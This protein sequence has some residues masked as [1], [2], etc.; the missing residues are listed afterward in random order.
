MTPSTIPQSSVLTF[1][2]GLGGS[3]PFG[4]HEG[5]RMS[6]GSSGSAEAHETIRWPNRTLLDTV[7]KIDRRRSNMRLTPGDE[8]L[9]LLREARA[10]G[11]YGVAQCQ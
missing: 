3:S 8:S 6:G 4:V 7:R 11:M 10:G 2:S 1:G 5:L 9:D